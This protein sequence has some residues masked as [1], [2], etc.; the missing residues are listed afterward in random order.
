[1]MWVLAGSAGLVV[2]M[3]VLLLRQRALII[4]VEGHSM[5]PTYASG[6]RLL[7]R[8]G[9]TCCTGDVVVFRVEQPLPDSPPMLVKRVAAVAGDPVPEAVRPA[10][11][12]DV[13]PDG[14]FVVLGDNSRSL[15]SRKLGLIPVDALV[16]TVTRQ[17]RRR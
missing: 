14:N 16:G 17:V 11:A 13:V 5:A 1:M 12:A 7:V 10:V 8:R 9:K 15:D 3:V 4:T 6:D 2:A